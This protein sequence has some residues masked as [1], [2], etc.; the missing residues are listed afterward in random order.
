MLEVLVVNEAVVVELSLEA[1]VDVTWLEMVLAIVAALVFV[2][3]LV[4]AVLPVVTLPLARD[5]L[6]VTEALD[7]PVVGGAV[8]VKLSVDVAADVALLEPALVVV[9]VPV[10]V[11][12]H[13]VTVLLEVPLPLAC[14]ALLITETLEDP[15]VDDAAGMGLMV[16]VALRLVL[17][18]LAV[19]VMVPVRVVTVLLEVTLPLVWY[20]LPVSEA[21]EV[22]VV[23]ADVDREL[24]V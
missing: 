4:V 5:A 23:D 17:A 24:T 16:E 11:P 6:L 3:V 10:S 1:A 19:P 9:A 2:P 8:V 13:V 12:V 7:V 14:H 22:P 15:V 21:M 18:V 20:A